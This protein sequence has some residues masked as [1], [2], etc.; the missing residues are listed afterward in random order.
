VT[1]VQQIA[2]KS[3]PDTGAEFGQYIPMS[4]EL[5]DVLDDSESDADRDLP[6]ALAYL[7]HECTRSDVPLTEWLSVL[8]DPK[9]DICLCCRTGNTEVFLYWNTDVGTLTEVTRTAD[10]RIAGPDTAGLVRTRAVVDT[11]STVHLVLH[12]STPFAWTTD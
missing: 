4:N 2:S 12:R 5:E 10:G 1:F 3:T 8:A 11:A 9:L 6:P 7:R